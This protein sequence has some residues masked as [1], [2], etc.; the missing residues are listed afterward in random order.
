MLLGGNF[1]ESVYY[2]MGL[3][4]AIAQHVEI[5]HH[6]SEIALIAGD[7][8]VLWDFVLIFLDIGLGGNFWIVELEKIFC[9]RGLQIFLDLA[10]SWYG[11][12]C[13]V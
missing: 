9:R 3:S 11:D 6:L 1:K 2:L 7:T 12:C 8:T 5:S 13:V 10:R 4:V